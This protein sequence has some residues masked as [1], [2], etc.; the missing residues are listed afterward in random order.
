MSLPPWGLDNQE[1]M[2]AARSRLGGEVDIPGLLKDKGYEDN[3]SANPKNA[4]IQSMIQKRIDGSTFHSEGGVDLDCLEDSDVY[5]DLGDDPD[6][7]LST[8][9]DALV[10]DGRQH[11]LNEDGCARLTAIL[12]KRKSV[13]GSGWENPLQPTSR[14]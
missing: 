3:A 13:F 2:T 7:E 9:L 14:Q 8:A 4:S 5:V 6:E 11:G 10:R 1:L 12:K